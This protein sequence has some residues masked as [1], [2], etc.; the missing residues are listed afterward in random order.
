M[1]MKITFC[2][3]NKGKKKLITKLEE[4]YPEVEINIKGCIGKCK[5]CSKSPIAKIKDE[6][7]VGEDKEDL[8][9]KIVK[10]IGE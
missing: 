8:Y 6:V 10:K 9:D 2:E 7:I 4:K 3:N 1:D 5:A